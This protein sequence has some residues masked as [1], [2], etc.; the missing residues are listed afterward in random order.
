MLPENLPKALALAAFLANMT[1]TFTINT[2]P[3]TP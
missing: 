3:L 2:G 1:R